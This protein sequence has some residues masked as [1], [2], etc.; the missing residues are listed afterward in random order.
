MLVAGHA[1]R[2]DR[3]YTTTTITTTTR[4]SVVVLPYLAKTM[5]RTPPFHREDPSQSRAGT[6]LAATPTAAATTRTRVAWYKTCRYTS[7]SRHDK[8]KGGLVFFIQDSSSTLDVVLSDEELF[9]VGWAKA[10]DPKSGSYYYFMLDRSKMV[11]DNPLTIGRGSADNSL[12]DLSKPVGTPG[13]LEAPV[14]W[15][16][17]RTRS[18]VAS[19]MVYLARLTRQTVVVSTIV[20]ARPACCRPTVCL[21]IGRRSDCRAN[22]TTVLPCLGSTPS[23]LACPSARG[24]PWLAILTRSHAR[25]HS[26]LTNFKIGSTNT[27]RPPTQV[28]RGEAGGSADGHHSNNSGG[29][30]TPYSA[31]TPTNTAQTH[32]VAASD[33]VHIPII[34]IKAESPQDVDAIISTLARGEIFIPHMS[35]LPE[36]LGIS[37]ISP[38][39][40]VICFSA[41]RNDDLPPDEWPNW[42]LAFMGIPLSSRSGAHLGAMVPLRHSA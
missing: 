28:A 1:E 31:S 39:D 24:T 27:F 9:S 41:E 42:C 4:S 29:G 40:L 10:L 13:E 38:P 2:F 17:W 15:E 26:T 5:Q 14:C 21:R 16:V 6:R 7:S 22:P 32:K 3:L 8:D 18:L 11:W 25:Q 35:I 23:L 19:L 30:D 33:T 36:A 12:V 37:G 20:A 34:N